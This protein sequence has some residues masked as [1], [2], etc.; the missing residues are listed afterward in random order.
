MTDS[1]VGPAAKKCSVAE[2]KL[3][4]G[5]C[6]VKHSYQSNRTMHDKW[7]GKLSVGPTCV[8]DLNGIDSDHSLGRGA[9][10][11]WLRAAWLRD[12]SRTSVLNVVRCEKSTCALSDYTRQSFPWLPS[13][14]WEYSA[15]FCSALK[16]AQ[17]NSHSQIVSTTSFNA[18]WLKKSTY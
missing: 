15:S 3:A 17:L 18:M 5:K 1:A 13:D 4:S 7:A 11:F 8:L 2:N 16:S 14:P 12:F 9:V 10:T 6:D